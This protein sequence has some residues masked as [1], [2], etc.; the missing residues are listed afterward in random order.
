MIADP[1]ITGVRAYALCPPGACAGCDQYWQHYERYAPT[2]P[3]AV[4]RLGQV[5]LTTFKEASA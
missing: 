3:N 4:A 5:D 2:N 1:D